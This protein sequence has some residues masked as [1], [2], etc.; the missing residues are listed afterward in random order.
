MPDGYEEIQADNENKD[1][2]IQNSMLRLL[3]LKKSRKEFSWEKK[4]RSKLK[5]Q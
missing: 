3:D 2:T 1:P 4:R 5:E